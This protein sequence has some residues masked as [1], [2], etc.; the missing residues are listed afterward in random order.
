[1]NT[2]SRSALL[3]AGIKAYQDAAATGILPPDV[4]AIAGGFMADHTAHRDALI[5]A[6]KASGNTPSTA[7]AKLTYPPLKRVN[8]ILAFAM[9]VERKAAST[10]LSVIPDLKDPGFRQAA[11]SILGVETTHV[12]LH[13]PASDLPRS[14]HPR[15]VCPRGSGCFRFG[16]YAGI[17]ASKS[18]GVGR[19]SSG[20]ESSQRDGWPAADAPC[21]IAHRRPRDR[22]DQSNRGSG[23]AL[24]IRLRR[25][26][27][28]RRRH[29]CVSAG[30]AARCRERQ[31]RVDAR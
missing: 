20:L 16:V 14:L 25:A 10:Y 6:V 2:L 30:R 24:R 29:G 18:T 9:V 3:G 22:G 1:M 13:A 21:K 23:E 15:D 19:S 8:D 28:F 17:G 5:A 27:L 7:T 31:A 11:A 4:L 12:A 26:D